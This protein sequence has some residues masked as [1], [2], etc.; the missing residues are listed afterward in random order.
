MS[1]YYKVDTVHSHYTDLTKRVVILQ[2]RYHHHHRTVT[3]SHHDI[4]E[5]NHHLALN[6]IHPLAPVYKSGI[7]C[8][9]SNLYI[10]I[11]ILFWSCSCPLSIK[12]NDVIF[13]QKTHRDFVTLLLTE[14]TYAIKLMQIRYALFAAAI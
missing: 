3:C 7:Q 14:C 13:W 2:S 1:L 12:H 11:H 9:I 6:N 8:S 5:T 10:N 4:V